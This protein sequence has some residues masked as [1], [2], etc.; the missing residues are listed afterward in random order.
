M[1]GFSFDQA[2]QMSSKGGGGFF[3][4]KNDGDVARVRLLFTDAQEVQDKYARSVHEVEVNGK[5][6]WVD[7]LRGYGDPIDVCP[8]CKAGRF[9][10]FKYFLP[11]FNIDANTT[12]IWERGKKFGGKLSSICSRYPNVVSHTFEIERCGK[13]GDQQ[14]SYE[15]YETGETAGVSIDDFDFQNPVGTLVMIKSA[16]DMQYYLNSGVFPDVGDS[17][18][19]SR[20]TNSAPTYTRRT[21]ASGS[22]RNQ[23]F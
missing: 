14:T 11:L 13:A 19:S 16:E 9:V 12:Q 2:E 21:P 4:L 15:M 3:S 8:F 20:N 23:V 7:C 1:A 6:R 18:S 10:N 22:G 17:H 5:K